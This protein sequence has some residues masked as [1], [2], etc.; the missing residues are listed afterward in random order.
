MIVVQ[1]SRLRR[2][3]RRDACTTSM[4][5]FIRSPKESE[6]LPA[7]RRARRLLATTLLPWRSD[8]QSGASPVARWKAWLL[9]A[10]L[11]AVALWAGARLLVALL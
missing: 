9:V 4:I 11:A 7:V 8:V 6:R 10:W 5:A 1:A 3:R 2:R